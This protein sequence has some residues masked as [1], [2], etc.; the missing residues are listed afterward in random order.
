MKIL[1]KKS[2]ASKVEKT[3]KVVFCIITLLTVVG[4]IGCSIVL[5]FDYNSSTIME[6][7]LVKTI[8]LTIVSIIFVLTGIAALFIIYQFI[9]IF[10]NLKENRLFERENLKA[11]QKVSNLSVVI[12]ILYFVILIIVSI[13]LGKYVVF[14]LSSRI[15]IE[16]LILV[17]SVVFLVFGIGIRVL[18]E[19][20]KKAIEYKEE[21]D[22][23]I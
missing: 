1:G 13:I 19:I 14:N 17:F 18:N 20:Y 16:V 4:F 6:N 9:N 21:N 12:G 7:Y 11:L 22:L 15:L 23:T 5:F 2:L 8:L 10:E 3:L